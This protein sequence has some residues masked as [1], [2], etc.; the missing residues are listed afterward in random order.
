M[1]DK[2]IECK[3]LSPIHIGTGDTFN[4]TQYIIKKGRLF[5][6]S[7]EKFL[8]NA[9]F[10]VI[11]QFEDAIRLNDPIAVRNFIETHVDPETHALYSCQVSAFVEALYQGKT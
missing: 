4:P 2:I 7:L 11:C 10:S 3:L 8:L 5:C 1:I 9:D 6:L